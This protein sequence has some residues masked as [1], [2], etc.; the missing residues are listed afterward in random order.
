MTN[1]FLE[2]IIRKYSE[3]IEYLLPILTIKIIA[4]IIILLIW[5][6][7][8]QFTLY[9]IEKACKLKAVDHL[10]ITFLKSLIKVILYIV[11][12]FVLIKILGIKATS[13]MTILGTA[14]IAVGLAL[15]G[16]LT[17]LAGGVL[18]LFFKHISK[19][20]YISIVGGAFEGEVK[21]IHMLYT[22]IIMPQGTI[23]TIP[24]SQI[25]NSGIIN[26]SKNEFRR[27]DLVYSTAYNNPIDKTISIL[28]QVAEEDERIIKKEKP[29][30]ISLIEH[31][32]SSLN[33]R[34]RVW[35]KNEDYF[36]VM[37]SCNRRVKI[38]FDENHIEIPFNK[39][40]VYMK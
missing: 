7:V 24:N 38:L 21:S 14:G 37:Y 8:I 25:A 36:E 35:V 39:L 9:T 30:V 34:F 27:L 2:N 17:N 40:D 1:F 10:L 15:Q 31:S 22:T 5:P 19:G 23:L 33:Y 3:K 12:I 16:S 6:K 28:R 29:I 13:L 32:A 26:Y 11:L 4:T 18:I 20:D